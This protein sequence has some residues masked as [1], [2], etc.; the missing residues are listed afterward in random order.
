[1]S[2][3]ASFFFFVT[4]VAS[5]LFVAT[6]GQDG[7]EA[8][9]VYSGKGFTREGKQEYTRLQIEMDFSK[10][11]PKDRGCNGLTF[12]LKVRHKSN[13]ENEFTVFIYEESFHYDA[14]ELVY[15]NEFFIKNI[16]TEKSL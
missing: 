7:D 3:F 2:K 10:I 1:M 8:K 15:L 5:S 12:L 13:N 11:N 9:V 14:E 4:V 16:D 6:L